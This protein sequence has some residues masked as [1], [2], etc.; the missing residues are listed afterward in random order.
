M[1]VIGLPAIEA[2]QLPPLHVVDAKG[3]YC[4]QNSAL[5]LPVDGAPLVFSTQLGH[6]WTLHVYSKSGAS[7]DVPIKPDAAQGRLCHRL[8]HEYWR[9]FPQG[10][11]HSNPKP[12]WQSWG[13]SSAER[14][15]GRWGFDAFEG[16]T[17]SLRTSRAAEW[18]VA[19]AD[20]TALIVGRDDTVH[21]KSNQAV[22]VKD[23][24]VE[25]AQGKNAQDARTSCSSRTNCKSRFR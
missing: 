22:C 7:L 2:P 4:L 21:L 18:T 16:P 3:V 12:I 5:V 9:P 20:S 6:D 1:L 8:A 11:N 17:L 19:S 13:L 14:I 25:D 23:V 24:T 10:I 15:K